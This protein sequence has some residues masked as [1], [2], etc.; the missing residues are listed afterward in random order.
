MA[1]SKAPSPHQQAAQTAVDQLNSG[2]QNT[3]VASQAQV[4]QVSQNPP[5]QPWNQTLPVPGGQGSKK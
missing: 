3:T 2:A 4:A 5:A 1:D